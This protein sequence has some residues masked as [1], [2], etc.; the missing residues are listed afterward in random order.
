MARARTIFKKHDENDQ[1]RLALWCKAINA[2][3]SIQEKA[4]AS[5]RQKLSSLTEDGIINLLCA[6]CS[7]IN[8]NAEVEK[9]RQ[10]CREDKTLKTIWEQRL[11]EKSYITKDTWRR[12]GK[13]AYAFDHYLG[14]VCY[15]AFNDKNVDMTHRVK[16]VLLGAKNQ[17]Y[18]A[19]LFKCQGILKSLRGKPDSLP[20]HQKDFNATVHALGNVFWAL[21]HL[22]AGCMLHLLRGIYKGQDKLSGMIDEKEVEDKML[23][24]F[25]K[26]EALIEFEGSQFLYS[27]VRGNKPLSEFLQ[28]IFGVDS[29]EKVKEKLKDNAGAEVFSFDSNIASAAIITELIQAIDVMDNEWDV[30]STE[31]EA[32]LSALQAQVKENAIN[33]ARIGDLLHK[34]ILSQG[35]PKSVQPEEQKKTQSSGMEN[36]K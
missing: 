36:Q 31:E 4:H 2:K 16:A 15:A 22:Q 27:A 11:K 24:E 12:D 20:Q 33:I 18:H 19:L 6:D 3:G 35:K 13:M 32:K 29:I 26:A 14:A 25:C 21:G 7:D 8:M 23:Q 10:F 34:D 9:I 1:E 5:V 17:N 28:Q 30:T